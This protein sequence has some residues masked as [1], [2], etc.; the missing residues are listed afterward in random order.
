MRAKELHC[1]R[2]LVL[3]ECDHVA[4][5]CSAGQRRQLIPKRAQ[6]FADDTLR[7]EDSAA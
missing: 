3:R 6:A 5:V 4:D 7:L 1:T 2:A